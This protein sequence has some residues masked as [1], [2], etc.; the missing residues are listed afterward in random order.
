MDHLVNSIPTTQ[1]T[2][3]LMKKVDRK[4]FVIH[5][6]KA[7]QDSPLPLMDKQTI[8]AP[9]MHARAIEYL[10]R[11]LKPGK[12]ILDIGSGSGYLTTCYAEAVKVYNPD[13]NQR[14]TV[15]GLEII[16]SLVHYSQNVIQNNFQHYLKYKRNFKILHKD[17]K[18]G[19]PENTK[20]EKYDGIHIG[21]ACDFIP[22]ALLAQLKKNG[23]MLIPLKINNSLY[24]T[25]VEKDNQG[26]IKINIRE[27]VRYVPLL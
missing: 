11:V 24:F 1:F 9:H 16:P 22:H 14:G 12:S 8:S 3:E 23:I 17:G 2:R 7:Y 10:E 15:I 25:V 20:I 4:H 13:P 26:N 5:K 27:P 21:A 6:N 19:F 18:K